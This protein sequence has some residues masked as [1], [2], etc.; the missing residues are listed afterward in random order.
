M[1]LSKVSTG[2][3]AA[4]RGTHTTQWA[5]LSTLLAAL[6]MPAVAQEAETT[7]ADTQ[8]A[9]E[10]D[11]EVIQVSGM[12]ATMTRSLT[13]KKN[14]EAITDSIA[15]ADF[16]DLPG[17]SISDV[18]ENITSVSGHRGKGSASEMS[19]R[20]LGPFLGYSTFNDRTI[21]SAGFS[22]AVNFKKFPSEF[23]DKVVVYKSQQADLVEGGV[24]GTINVDSLRPLDYGKDQV[25]LELQGIYNNHT[26]HTDGENGLGN[27]VTASFV[28]QLNNAVLGNFAITAGYQRTDSSNPEESMLTSSTMYACATRLADGT[29]TRTVNDCNSTSSN[30]N[31]SVTRAN[32][33]N[34]D[35]S[36]VFLTP[37]S[38]TFRNQEEED[39]RD[40]FVT[41][42]QWQPNDAWNINFDIEY[43]NNTYFEDRHDF[44]IA[45]ARRN[46]RNHII[47]DELN[48]LYREGDSRM[49]TQGLYRNEDETYNGWGLNIEHNLTDDLKIS[50][51]ISYSKSYRNRT[52]YQ[53]RIISNSY[54][55]YSIDNTA[56]RLSE[57]QFLDANWN[58]PGD[59][60]YNSSTAFDPNN[61]ASWSAARN[62]NVNPEA[63]YRRLME[64][65]FDRLGAIR[66][67]LEYYLGGDVFS[68]IHAGVR[69]SEEE[70]FSDLDT[71]RAV[72]PFTGAESSEFATRDATL[73]N[74]VV[75]NCFIDWNNPDWLSSESGSGFADGQFAQLN[76]RCGF[77]ILSG[78]N[79]DGSFADIGP[80]ADVRSTGD[81]D[82]TESITAVYVMAKLQTQLFGLPVSGNIG[83]RAVQTKI[84]SNGI[85]SG[86]RVSTNNTGSLTLEPTG[87]IEEFNI[88]NDTIDFLPSANITFHYSDTFLIRAAAYRA[89]SRPQLLDMSAGRDIDVNTEDTITN[90]NDLI[91]QVSGGNP[92]QT[93]LMSNSADLSLEWYP[94][95][96]TA[97]SI[98]FYVKQ[99]E[100]NF[101]DVVVAE[102][103]TIDG[104]P[105][106]VQLSTSTYTDDASY[107]RGVELSAQH[108]FVN[109][110]APFDGLGV[111]L[112]YNYA[113][114]SFENQDGTFGDVFDLDGNLTQAGFVE[115]ANV[116][117]LSE[118]V[119][120]GSV[121]W[122]G[123][124][125]SMR[126]LYKYRSQYFQPNSG[127]ASNRYVEPFN[128][129]DFSAKYKMT[130]ATSISFQALNITDEAQYMTRGASNTP[131]LV[132]SSG[133]K[134]FLSLKT[135]F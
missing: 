134:Y 101:R 89:M 64:E 4:S 120:S 49:E 127:A 117:G 95:M 3:R 15:A 46:L 129:V 81:V 23:S 8:K 98:A 123:K 96:D 42:L 39:T 29:P 55:K 40:A 109:L 92:Y 83:L 75:N 13:L 34:Y 104:Q 100:A 52:D 110:P 84:D 131:T 19:I 25:S 80:F 5:L 132:S 72:N 135:V 30:A 17:L 26:A 58:S 65:R 76:G 48:L 45:S 116:F 93:P 112:S 107:L 77:G 67:D 51:D 115:P 128:Y 103:L 94:S 79:A 38:W 68:S 78:V 122:E 130:K 63:R 47:D 2:I 57:V 102:T 27:Q 60:G 97:Y 61:I 87:T 50:T 82:I 35:R 9:A 105:I 43:S 56:H 10:V 121:Y 86:Y 69:Y 11:V 70:L 36:S 16:G 118:D 124:K 53:S 90:P 66:F 37:S 18:I 33:D 54:W 1:K 114:S 22:R 106:D 111:K 74:A 113:N 20:G 85:R 62:N 88:K 133:P 6:A 31:A 91:R 108:N 41:A 24:A 126:V 73:V 12:R 28:K 125:F 7:A 71:T 44:V 119:F 59:A 32:I 21:T 14:T 99:F